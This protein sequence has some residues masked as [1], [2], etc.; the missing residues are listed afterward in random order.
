MDAALYDPE[1]GYYMVRRETRKDFYTAPELHHSFG[2][3]LAHYI[4]D[5]VGNLQK[6]GRRAPGT[7]GTG[8]ADPD[9]VPAPYSIVEMGAADGLLSEHLIRTLSKIAPEIFIQCRFILVEKSP[10]FRA[11]ALERL[12]LYGEQVRVLASLDELEPVNGIFL[13]N[14]L[15]DAFPMHLIEK[16][17][18]KLYE[19]YVSSR[20]GGEGYQYNL[21]GFSSPELRKRAEAV[22]GQIP[23]GCRFAINLEAVR[24]LK[25]VSAKLLAG[26]VVT[27]DYG[28][29]FRG[30]ASLEPKFFYRHFHSQTPMQEMG[31]EDITCPVDFEALIKDGEA[32]GLKLH[33]FSSLG[34]FL[35]KHGILDYLPA[36]MTQAAM[37]ARNQVKTL[38]H[39]EGMG[40]IFKVLIQQ[41]G[42]SVTIP[43]HSDKKEV[44]VA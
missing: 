24:W 4:A 33:S 34:S 38:F 17:R 20:P 16:A 15:V 36:G 23:E 42:G 43:A 5:Q 44:A 10:K 21:G 3:T 41:K 35:I 8:G 25:S 13:S 14:E 40:D 39:P 29:R 37:V 19:V 18:G 7:W 28:R 11:A 26:Q 30:V 31:R 9:G 1:S 32:Q 2:G 22:G 6:A 12:S 27:I